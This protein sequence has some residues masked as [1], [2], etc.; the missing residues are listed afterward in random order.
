MP[1]P[2]KIGDD[3]V[4]AAAGE[5][6]AR[7]GP[8]ALT[9]ASV[10]A[11]AGLSPASLVQRYGSRDALMRATLLSLWDGLDAATARADALRPVSVEGAIALLAG[12]SGQYDSEEEQA[13]GLLLLREDFRDPVLRARGVRWGEALALALGRRLTPDAA[14]QPLLGRLMASQWQGCLIWW[15][16]SRR[17]SL[18]DFVRKELREWCRVVLGAREKGT[19]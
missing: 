13:Q 5:I 15:G 8:E 1:R 2:K 4:L 10:G 7:G 18:R 11:A 9:F 17:G 19:S 12:L 14:M 6:V 16:F 3:M